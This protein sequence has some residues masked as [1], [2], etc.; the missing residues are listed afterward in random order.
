MSKHAATTTVLDLSKLTVPELGALSH[1]M[2]NAQDAVGL[3]VL[4]TGDIQMTEMLY[5]LTILRVEVRAAFLA[6]FFDPTKS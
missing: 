1:A 6:N 4:K 3:Q 5:E 2:F